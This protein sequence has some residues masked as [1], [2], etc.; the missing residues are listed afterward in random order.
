MPETV[1][2]IQQLPW[3]FGY[4]LSFNINR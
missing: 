2:Q 4:G 3:Y 1:A